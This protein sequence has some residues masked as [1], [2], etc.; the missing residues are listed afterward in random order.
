MTEEKAAPSPTKKTGGGACLFKNKT[1]KTLIKKR[2]NV[3]LLRLGFLP[4]HD[5]QAD[6]QHDHAH[7]DAHEGALQ[8]RLRRP[9]LFIPP[10]KIQY[11]ARKGNKKA[12]HHVLPQMARIRA[13]VKGGIP[14]FDG[15]GRQV[16]LAPLAFAA[17]RANHRAFIQLFAAKFTPNG[18]SSFLIQIIIKL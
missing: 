12:D 10:H 2:G 6:R 9:R 17:A 5:E 14:L 15:R 4:A 13:L 3:R 1:A 8:A 18:N 16:D 7:R 11:D